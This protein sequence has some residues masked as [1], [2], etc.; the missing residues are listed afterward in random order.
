M[1]QALI[2][3]GIGALVILVGLWFVTQNS[4]PA[5]EM[6]Y[7]TSTEDK[8]MI[9][10]FS[11]SSTVFAAGASIPSKYTC[12]AED[13]SPPLSWVGAPEGTQSFVLI[14]DDPDAGSAGWV[15]W[16][17]FN[18]SVTVHGV[19]EGQEPEG[20]AGKNSWGRAGWGGPCPPS[21]THHYS[22]R[23]YALDTM[24]GLAQG[25]TKKDIETA[26]NGHV[27]GEAELIG[28]YQRH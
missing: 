14:M 27:L 20:M 6:A 13:V 25:A 24:L 17:V 19:D 26:M 1:K 10:P 12:D 11:I 18:I 3:V 4:T 7:N 16:V 28:L 22:F 8:L 21:G 5:P 15:H 9:E 23:I 2:F